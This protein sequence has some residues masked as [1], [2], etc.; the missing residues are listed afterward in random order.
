MNKKLIVSHQEET[1][2]LTDELAVVREKHEAKSKKL[3]RYI[4]VAKTF[5]A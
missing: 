4:A 5:D 1:K 2:R 3:E